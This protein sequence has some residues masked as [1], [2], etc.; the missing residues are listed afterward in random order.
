[1][2]DL[3]QQ[4]IIPCECGRLMTQKDLEFWGECKACRIKLPIQTAQMHDYPS[5][6]KYHGDLFERGEW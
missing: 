5:D 2:S 6:R 4:R 3:Q 1:M